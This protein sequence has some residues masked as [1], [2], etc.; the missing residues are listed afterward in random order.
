MALTPQT[1][2]V[3]GG[4]YNNAFQSMFSLERVP[5][6]WKEYYQVYGNK[7]DMFDFID[8]QGRTIDLKG[9]TLKIFYKY[10]QE[11]PIT[12]GTGGIS[13]GAA[14]ANITFKLD[15]GDYDTNN[16]CAL[17]VT[18][19]IL[20]PGA[21]TNSST[22]DYLYNVISTDSGVGAN[23]IYTA[24]PF[25]N[26]GTDFTAAQITTA[27]PA[28]TKLMIAGDSNTLASDAPTTLNDGSLQRSYLTNISR[29]A[30]QIEGGMLAEENYIRDVPLRN[31]KGSGTL[32]YALV[33]QEFDL[34]RKINYN[35][36][37][38][39]DPDNASMTVLGTRGFLPWLNKLAAKKT[40]SDSFQVSDLD[41]IKP[42]MI[43]NGVTAQ[44]ILF[45]VGDLLYA[46]VEN[47]SYDFIKEFSH[48]TDI[49]KSM[50]ELG[51]NFKVLNKLA[52]KYIVKEFGNLS[53]PNGMGLSAYGDKYRSMGFMVPMGDIPVKLEGSMTDGDSVK[54][55]SLMLGYLNNN[56]ENRT[57][58]IYGINGPTGQPGM[59]ISSI[60][61][62][63][64]GMLSEYMFVP[65]CVERM[66]LVNKL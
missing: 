47:G 53:N 40:Y 14:G 3:S 42:L 4:S 38:G 64:G 29:T 5:Q 59:T 36:W 15:A 11:K 55:S 25:Y 43:S 1:S 16:Q 54:I 18:D 65:T 39:Q 66:V 22:M 61:V 46:D 33:Q 28:G 20:I 24:Q 2:F 9:R 58:V 52:F 37:T 27:I 49:M 57:R 19:S 34:N 6:V 13:T 32:N 50:N 60:D 21:Y 17:R 48:G 7:F 26:A 10:A 51:L 12:I 41:D 62:N 31:G 63:K 30:F 35:I 23:K 8:I 56:N 44:E 45:G